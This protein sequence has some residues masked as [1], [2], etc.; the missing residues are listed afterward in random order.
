MAEKYPGMLGPPPRAKPPLKYARSATSSLPGLE[1]AAP[2]ASQ[3]KRSNSRLSGQSHT[4]LSGR[5]Q[6]SINSPLDKPLPET[7]SPSK[8]RD[9]LAEDI[10]DSYERMT[11]PYKKPDTS[12]VWSNSSEAF[13][14][15]VYQVLGP[16]SDADLQQPLYNYDP[17]GPYAASDSRIV[18]AP[19]TP[20]T[21]SNLNKSRFEFRE[22]FHSQRSEYS[23]TPS[24][25][26]SETHSAYYKTESKGASAVSPICPL[27]P[28]QAQTLPPASSY[29]SLY[30]PPSPHITNV[31]DHG[32]VPSPLYSSTSK[33]SQISASM[34]SQLGTEVSSRLSN[35][36]SV[37]SSRKASIHS[38]AARDSLDRFQGK[39]F[40]SPPIQ[41]NPE[42]H[43]PPPVEIVPK[44]APELAREYRRASVSSP[45]AP[46]TPR[47]P[48][49]KSGASIQSGI[50]SMYDTLTG[51]APSKSKH[52]SSKSVPSTTQAPR[53]AMSTPIPLERRMPAISM[54]PY[55]HFSTKAWEL[56]EEKA[57]SGKQLQK[58]K[59]KK[60]F[61]EK[62][63]SPG[64]EK[65]I[66]SKKEKESARKREELKGKIR[67]I[68]LADQMPDGTVNH[69]L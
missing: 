7:P 27:T 50:T 51:L 28:F 11:P 38:V 54:T 3:S 60:G 26:P 69:W 66:S 35:E 63:V 56:E 29:S 6:V 39:T 44:T 33:L 12:S 40:S 42:R 65:K 48:W 1:K 43:R 13:V 37:A 23:F 21:L 34:Q 46:R 24:V 10:I 25:A 9:F 58:A 22:S 31:V 15:P 61:F 55:Q 17:N 32:L 2:R 53:K 45:R 36:F 59:E 68:G 30:Y 49:R 18:K 57:K 52:K 20:K 5:S 67:V 16:D 41:N 19:R 47:S 8:L 64:G 4:P 62:V 14:S